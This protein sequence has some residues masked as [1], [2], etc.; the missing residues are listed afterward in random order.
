MHWISEN[1]NL[2]LEIVAVIFGVAY[3]VCIAKNKIIGWIF[4]IIGSLISIVLFYR[5]QLMAEALLYIYY[6]VAGVQGYLNWNKQADV[7]EVYNKGV[8]YHGMIIGLGLVLGVGLYYLIQAVFT[9]AARPLIDSFTTV[10]SFLA[11]YLTVKKIIEN[12]IY[13]IV[14][15]AVTVYLY[16]SRELFIYSG[17]MVVYTVLA[18]LG[19]LEWKKM[20]ITTSA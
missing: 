2:I 1:L 6:V 8:N 7:S 4:G 20:K 13:W 11:T 10:F 9:D 16:F 19:Y 12:W 17:L 3:V 14:I 18:Y 15:D 5:T